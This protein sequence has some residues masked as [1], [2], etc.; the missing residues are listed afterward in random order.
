MLFCWEAMR[1]GYGAFRSGA[2]LLEMRW[3]LA[4]FAV[5]DLFVAGVLS[6]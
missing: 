3:D 4:V 2:V 6:M 5:T 1:V